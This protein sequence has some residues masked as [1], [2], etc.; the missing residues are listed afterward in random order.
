MAL[1]AN[2]NTASVYL[3]T[4][5][6]DLTT[7]GY[8]NGAINDSMNVTLLNTT[9]QENQTLVSGTKTS[10]TEHARH[11]IYIYPGPVICSFGMVCNILNLCVLSQPDLSDSPYTYLTAIAVADLGMLT[12]SFSHLVSFTLTPS[13]TKAIYDVY[14]FYGIGNIFFTSSVWFIVIMTIERMFFVV[15]PFQT[16]SSVKKARINIIIVVICSS[17]VNIP[18]FLCYEIKEYENTGLY[19]IWGTTFQKSDTFYKTSWFQAIMVTLIPLVILMVANFILI[20]G[21]HRARKRREDLHMN[22]NQ[23]QSWRKN[24]VRLTRTLIGVVIVFIVCT[25][26][27]VFVEDPIAYAFFSEDKTWTEYLRSPGNQTFIYVSN[28]LLFLNCSLNFILYCAFNNKFRGALKNFFA[29]FRI[30]R[31]R[32]SMSSSNKP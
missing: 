2:S 10:V 20:M 12:T 6:M 27:S 28:L 31:D 13:F 25:L 17:L 16:P 3:P 29:R 7:S 23:E 32:A 11:A 1:T 26:P 4:L 19:F 5:I 24:E 30:G 21:L 8:D 18:R 14:I 9:Y 15:R 22:S